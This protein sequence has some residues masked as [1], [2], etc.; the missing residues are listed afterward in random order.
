MA[1]DEPKPAPSEVVTAAE[2]PPKPPKPP[3]PVVVGDG[4]IIHGII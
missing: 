3:D 2:K 4:K 1:T